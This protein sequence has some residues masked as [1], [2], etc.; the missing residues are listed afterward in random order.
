[1]TGMTCANC[2][3]N[4]ERT[5]NRKVPG[6]IE[7]S[8]NFATEKEQVGFIPSVSA[9]EDIVAVI[10]KA[11]YDAILPEEAAE[12][13]DAEQAAQSAE[14]RDQTRK[15]TAGVLFSHPLFLLSMASGSG[16]EVRRT[17]SR[18]RL[19]VAAMRSKDGRSISPSAEMMAWRGFPSC[20]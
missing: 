18:K 19:P 6:V 5:L 3:A 1:M 15:F 2:P 11:G 8:V 7:A 12:G 13:E 4:I 16:I 14:T 20:G 9:L 10:R 17:N